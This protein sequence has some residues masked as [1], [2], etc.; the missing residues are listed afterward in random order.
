V[1]VDPHTM[2]GWVQVFVNHN[3]ITHLTTAAR[4]L[5]HGTFA[6]GEVAWCWLERGT[7]GGVRAAHHASVRQGAVAVGLSNA[8]VLEAVQH[9]QA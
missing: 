1:F 2:P 5:M 4:G 7:G 3:P 8:A 6:A 9:R